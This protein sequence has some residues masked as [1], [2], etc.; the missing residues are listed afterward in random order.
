MKA[1]F[2]AFDQAHYEDVYNVLTHNNCRGFTYWQDVQGRGTKS[3]EP[4]YGSQ[5]C[6]AEYELGDS[7][8][9]RRDS[10]GYCS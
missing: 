8:G 9:C 10:F 5:P 2:I 3:G 6:L 7:F 1:L 4:H